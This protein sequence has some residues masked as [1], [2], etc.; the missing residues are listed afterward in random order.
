MRRPLPKYVL[1]HWQP[2]TWVI[3]PSFFLVV[4]VLYNTCVVDDCARGR[5]ARNGGC[6]THNVEVPPGMPYLNL[7]IKAPPPPPEVLGIWA[8]STSSHQ[9]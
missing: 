4:K 3:G 5:S 7:V 1:T 2:Q 6:K 9:C 8:R